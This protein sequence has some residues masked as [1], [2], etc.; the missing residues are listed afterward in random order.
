MIDI[1]LS[2]GAA[3]LV[4]WLVRRKRRRRADAVAGGESVGVPCMVRW[5]GRRARWKAG[6]LVVGGVGPLVWKPAFGSREVAL[7]GGLR[8]AGVRTPSLREAVSINPG[9]RIVRCVSSDGEIL[10]AV[11]PE[12]L[13]RVIKALESA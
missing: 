9:S 1:V 5:P 4:G 12:D 10:I 11:M 2:V 3:V 13:D 8:R 7:P 6:R